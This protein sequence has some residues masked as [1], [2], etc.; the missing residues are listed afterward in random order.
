MRDG[1]LG[2]VSQQEAQY[3]GLTV[4]EAARCLELDGP[5]ELPRERPRSLVA[6]TWS[7]VREP[8]ILLLLGAATISFL[9][10][11]P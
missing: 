8:M 9:L 11:D 5:N 3:R 10:A 1:T 2:E 7:V 4:H 6:S